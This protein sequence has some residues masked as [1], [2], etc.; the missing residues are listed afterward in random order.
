[1][2]SNDELLYYMLGQVS[3]WQARDWDLPQ[4]LLCATNRTGSHW[5]RLPEYYNSL[6]DCI[7]EPTASGING[8]CNLN[9]YSSTVI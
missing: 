3:H 1:M 7:T 9:L 6:A 8:R 4:A 5:Q 2:T